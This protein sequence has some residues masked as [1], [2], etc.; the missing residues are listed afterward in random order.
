MCLLC[1]QNYAR[2]ST[3]YS[4]YWACRVFL[5]SPFYADIPPSPSWAD[6][7]V[8]VHTAQIAVSKDAG[9]KAHSRALACRHAR[10]AQLCVLAVKL[11]HNTGLLCASMSSTSRPDCLNL[12][13]ADKALS[14]WLP[15][16]AEAPDVITNRN[17]CNHLV[18]LCAYQLKK[19]QDQISN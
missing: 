17:T 7:C 18:S 19:N 8:D 9:A 1:T 3:K 16:T 4:S 6:P 2:L 14:S 10:H 11:E 12:W 15:L 13:Y 5:R